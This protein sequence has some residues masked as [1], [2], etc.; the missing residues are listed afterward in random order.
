MD[1]LINNVL[2]FT[3]TE[4]QCLRKAFDIAEERTKS[5]IGKQI[6]RVKRY[7]VEHYENDLVMFL[8]AGKKELRLSNL[9][10]QANFPKQ[11]ITF[12]K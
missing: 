11:V 6:F 10:S 7:G 12:V 2:V 8:N 1:I 9:V 3:G 4:S 5:E